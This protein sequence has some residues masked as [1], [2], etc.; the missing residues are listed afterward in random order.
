MGK[1]VFLD[2]QDSFTYNLVDELKSLN[3]D[4]TVYRNTVSA[5]TILE[6]IDEIKSSGEIPVLFLSPGPG[7]PS[8]SVCMMT[9]LKTLAGNIPIIGV[10]L[11]HQA[12]AEHFGAEV[13]L[14]GETV[15]GKSSIVDC[16]NHPI[17]EG[18]GP[19]MNVARYHSLA[20]KALPENL[21]VIANYKHIPMAIADDEKKIIGFQFHPESILT[22]QGSELLR[23]TVRYLTK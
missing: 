10:C 22:T 4:V 13:V 2:N 18:L 6:T 23:Q 12:I 8:D 19:K 9:L 16:N 11:G 21:T 20:V 17:F 3:F 15:H 5:N 14:A 7:K 1:I